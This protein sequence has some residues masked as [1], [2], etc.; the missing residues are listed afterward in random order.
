MTA[1]DPLKTDEMT[2]KVDH[3]F[4]SSRS[5]AISYFFLKGTDTQPLSLTGNIPWVD[6]DFAWKQQNL[7]VAN[8]WILS[9]TKIN[10]LRFTYV[11]A[12]WRAPQQPDDVTRRSE[13][14]FPDSGRSHAAAHHGDRVLHRADVDRGP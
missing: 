6:R 10:Q 4:S 14:E 8:T 12:V 5:F 9:S 11:A 7:N 13:L 1:P 3:S 2:L